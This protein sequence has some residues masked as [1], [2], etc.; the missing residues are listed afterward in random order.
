MSVET[1]GALIALLGIFPLVAGIIALIVQA[2][3]KGSKRVPVLLI[4]FAP[5]MFIA[6]MAS[7]MAGSYMGAVI[8]FGIYILIA[9]LCIRKKKNEEPVY[10]TAHP[11]SRYDTSAST[12]ESK[13]EGMEELKKYKYLLD[14]GAITEEEFNAKKKQILGL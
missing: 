5:T 3:R 7:Y 8:V 1:G 2:A 10:E 12:H 6:G 14:M 11:V 4:C 13:Q 9:Y